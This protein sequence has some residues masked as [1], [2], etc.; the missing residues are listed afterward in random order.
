L[1]HPKQPRARRYA[2]V[3][4]A[5]ITMVDTALQIKEKTTDISLYGCHVNTKTPWTMGT[6]V[7]VRI[8]HKGAA[9][10]AIGTVAH[11]QEGAGMGILFTRIEPNQQTVLDKWLAELR[12]H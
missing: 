7:R 12:D 3:A 4:A 8:S 10:S 11:V 2:F 9:F 5:E 1:I 6:K